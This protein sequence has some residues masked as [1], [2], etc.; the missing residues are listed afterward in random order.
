MKTLIELYDELPMENV[1]STEVFRPERT[2]FICPPEVAA[3]RALHETLRAYFRRRGVE[4]QL[5]FQESSLLDAEKVAKCLKRVIAEYP[6]CALDISGGTDAALF[7][8]GMVSA[9]SDIPVFTY[10]RKRNLYFNIHNAP[11]A[12]RLTCGVRLRVEDCFLMAGGAMRE[13]RVD[14]GILLG[15]TDAIG[16]L[17]KIYMNRRRDWT[18]IVT[19]IQRISQAG[20]GA[21]DATA[22]MAEGE[23]TVKGERGARIEAPMEALADME[24]AGLIHALSSE[25]DMVRFVFSDANVRKWLRDVGSVLELEVWKTCV[26][27]GAFDDV[28][29]SAVVD[30]AGAPVQDGVSNEID[31][32]ATKGVIPV[33]ISCKTCDVKT[34]A[35][36]ELAILRDR[37]GGKAARAAIVTGQSGGAAMRRRAQELQI[38]VIDGNDLRSGAYKDQL[39][40]LAKHNLG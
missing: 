38:D 4:A 2:V 16:A 33:F 21:A 25:D 11:F 26:Q 30:W 5:V 9:E 28:V 20:Q 12:H 22:L 31:V 36:N 29:T 23:R 15:Y 39:P 1:M 6:E 34:E 17:F 19:Y 3:N 35:L 13:G 40:Q 7:A 14:N 27:S 10:S 32:M 8:G 24:A 37:F 18:R